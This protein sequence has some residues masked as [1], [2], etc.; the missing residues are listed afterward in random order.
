MIR[1]ADKKGKEHICTEAEWME[2]Q[3]RMKRYP[4]LLFTYIGPFEAVKVGHVKAEPK[5]ARMPVEIQRVTGSKQGADAGLSDQ[6]VS[7]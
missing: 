3:V 5:V 4:K 1:Y 7:N 6:T 2:I